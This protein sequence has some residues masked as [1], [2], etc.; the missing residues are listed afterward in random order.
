MSAPQLDE[1]ASSA[2]L[3]AALETCVANRGG[4]GPDGVTLAAFAQGASVELAR[5]GGELSSGAYRPHPSRRV[6]LP[7]PGGGHRPIAIGCVRDRVVQAAVARCLSAALDGELHD[8]AWGYRPGRSALGAVARVERALASGLTWV[9]RGDVEQFFDRIPPAMLLAALQSR[10]ADARVVELVEKLLGAGTL[11]GGGVV[12]PTLGTP[13]GSPLSPFLANLYLEPFDR[14]LAE[15]GFEAVRYGDD[16]CVTVESRARAVE[17]HALVVRSLARLRLELNTNKVEIRQHGEGFAFLGFRFVPSGR[18]A[19]PRA[20]RRLV[21]EIERV[22]AERPRDGD[23][24]LD[25]LLR[26]W[27]AYYGSL[28]GVELPAAVRERAE[29][30]EADRAERVQYGAAHLPRRG[31]SRRGVAASDAEP[32]PPMP[33]GPWQRAVVALSALEGDATSEEREA[34]RE[35]LRVDASEWPEVAAALVRGDG[36]AVAER[37][38]RAGRFADAAEAARIERVASEDAARAPGLRVAPGEA[39][40]AAREPPRLTIDT[41]SAERMLEL[42]AGAEH[43]FQRDLRVGER[44]E[45]QRVGAPLGAAQ[46]MAHLRGDFWLGVF[47]LRANSSARFGAVRLLTAAKLRRDPALPDGIAPAVTRSALGLRAALEQQGL[48]ALVSLEPRRG[49]TL[50]LFL[51][52]P[53]PAPRIRALLQLTLGQL[54]PRPLEVV[55]ELLPG[56]DSVRPDKPGTAALLPLGLDPRTGERGWLLDGALEPMTEPMAALR[57]AK[58]CSKAEIGA[59]LGLRTVQLPRPSAPAAD[60][61]SVPQAV[62]PPLD[63]ATLATTP[64]QDLPRAQ[65]VYAGC[66]VVR[67]LVDKALTGQGLPT[68]ERWFVADALGRLGDESGP[69]LEAVLRHLDDYR[70]GASSR[71]L[72]RLY[73]RPTSCGRTRQNWPELTSRIGCDCRF[74]VPPGAYP[75][76]VLHAVGAAQVPGL[77]DRVRDASSRGGIARAALAAMNEGRKELGARA[78]ALCARLAD[79]RRQQKGLAKTIESVER[80]LDLVLD[81]AGDTALDTPSGTLR[82]VDDNGT[83]RFVLDV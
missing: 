31:A 53:T 75:T 70:P 33:R 83:R 56:Q 40:D 16:L 46:V 74:R 26:G 66:N 62:A 78:S 38:A 82:R 14:A 6:L 42:F 39:D 4:P 22:A 17:A 65:E 15:A 67:H 21:E 51:A 1:I 36:A 79:L 47:P 60:A 3:R 48:T 73:P 69:A 37:L 63:A 13:Q 28:V 72:A 44:I 77:E 81:E 68:S 45:R 34:V 54:G 76:P 24:E 9:L 55:A 52:E 64:F 32:L 35:S 8:S 41:A 50:W 7:K 61:A 19:A 18:R 57:D 2:A 80:E 59:A 25:E 49:Y 58:L 43:T 5:L 20:E 23:E 12:D 71:L 11:T 10:V 29:R 30:L 27:L